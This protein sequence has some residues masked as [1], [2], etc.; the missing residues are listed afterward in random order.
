MRGVEQ[1]NGDWRWE[2]GLRPLG[3]TVR[4]MIWVGLV[5]CLALGL[6]GHSVVW[7]AGWGGALSDRL[8]AFPNWESRPP[9]HAANGDLIYPDWFAG[10]WRVETTLVDLA[11]PFA[12][13]LVTPGFESTRAYLDQPITFEARFG[14]QKRRAIGWLPAPVAS[15]APIVAD[16]A[17]NGQNLATAYLK[18]TN[19]EAPNPLQAVKVDPENPNRQ[20]T[21]FRGD[22]QLISTVT[23]RRTE[24]PAPHAFLTCEIFQQE[25]RSPDSIYVSQVE[26]TTAYTRPTVDP[27]DPDAPSFTADQVTAIYLSPQDPDFFET[28]DRPVA[29][30]RY[31]LTFYPSSSS[32][33]QNEG[34]A[35]SQPSANAGMESSIPQALNPKVT[36]HQR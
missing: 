9:V 14:P 5:A 17:F 8:Q 25:F 36:R 26:T 18:T 2:T 7:A 13:D 10:T 4:G 16:R 31:H 1:R 35:N 12:P 22:R 19:P 28:G 29:L 33:A 15:R 20:I 6:G 23:A 34:A 24:T 11:A 32:T 21:L 3:A 30:Y 27:L